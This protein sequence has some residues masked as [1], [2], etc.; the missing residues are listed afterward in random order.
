M[1]NKLRKQ[2]LF[3]ILFGLLFAFGCK[4]NEASTPN[5]SFL[6][7]PL[8]NRPTNIPHGHDEDCR[9][10]LKKDFNVKSLNTIIFGDNFSGQLKHLTGLDWI[11]I[12]RPDSILEFNQMLKPDS[13]GVVYFLE[14]VD[15]KNDETRF[16]SIGSDDGVQVWVN[17]DSL[18][19]SHKGRRVLPFDDVV[20]VKLKKG[21][22]IVLF[23][24]DQ[25]SGGWGLYRKWISEFE[26][27]H[28][29]NNQLPEIYGDL[30]EACIIPD[31]ATSILLKVNSKIKVD[32]FH[33]LKIRWQK[34]GDNLFETV[35]KSGEPLSRVPLPKIF[36]TSISI[37]IIVTDKFSKTVFSEKMPI[38]TERYYQQEV[39]NF[40]KKEIKLLSK[41]QKAELASFKVMIRNSKKNYSSKMRS[42]L[43][44][45]LINNKNTDYG[46]RILGY[47]S[48]YYKSIEPYRV[49][50]PY[51]K[52]AEKL[53][54][55]FITTGVQKPSSQFFE[56]Y[57]GGSHALLS[58][59][60][61]SAQKN[62]VVLVTRQI[63]GDQKKMG[64]TQTELPEILKDLS[65]EKNIDTTNISAI[66]WSK[67]CYS[68]LE[69][70]QEKV[71]P[72]HQLALISVV[73]PNDETDMTRLLLG[74]KRNYPKLKF[75]V[76]H[77]MND[78]EAPLFIVRKFEILIKKMGFQIDY[79]EVPFSSHWSFIQDP[80]NIFYNSLTK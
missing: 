40:L 38:M 4:E 6:S 51:Q 32:T 16:L 2:F 25:T 70:L 71:I 24:I 77:G 60:I 34:S 30:I 69:L 28:K 54:I 26:V 59:R 27:E 35:I 47:F 50:Y 10:F 53:P 46:T 49:F 57:E 62:R 22:N 14:R 8:P 65:T 80:E 29:I 44:S 78:E 1:K 74:V 55:V 3:I 31:T 76:R 42:L 67:D 33:K 21:S 13:N 15:C 64:D 18:L 45:D 17:G 7:D 66:V 48:N 61:I 19:F 9:G 12:E 41:D 79:E 56:S 72:L 75:F 20:Q 23:K 37:E 11:P 43:L 52:S 68:F 63:R 39:N 73:L 58:S 5:Y 36:D